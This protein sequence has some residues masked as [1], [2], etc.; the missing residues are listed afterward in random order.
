MSVPREALAF[1]LKA[2]IVFLVLMKVAGL[3]GPA[4]VSRPD[5]FAGALR[6]HSKLKDHPG[7]VSLS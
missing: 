6:T 7:W 3:P 5:L 4:L 2:L 1:L